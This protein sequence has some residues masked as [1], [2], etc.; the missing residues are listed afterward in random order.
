MTVLKESLGNRSH[1]QHLLEDRGAVS[2]V[3]EKRGGN[4]SYERSSRSGFIHLWET[5]GT[6]Q[7]KICVNKNTPCCVFN[8][9]L[10]KTAVFAYV[11][12]SSVYHADVGVFWA[13]FVVLEEVSEWWLVSWQ[14]HGNIRSDRQDRADVLFWIAPK[15]V[16][17]CATFGFASV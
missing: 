1:W 2:R 3:L 17:P 9:L 11:C 13:S 15:L 4:L 14:W 7:A 16:W 5:S 10:E 6:H 8:L 12:A